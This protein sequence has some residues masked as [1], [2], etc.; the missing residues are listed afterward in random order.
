MPYATQTRYYYKTESTSV[1]YALDLDGVIEIGYQPATGGAAVSIS[2]EPTWYID[3]VPPEGLS[4]V[5]NGIAFD[6]AGE[7]HFTRDG[8]LFRGWNPT[9][10]AATSAG[11][12][13]T[14]GRINFTSVPAG[15]ANAISWRNAAHDARGALDIFGGVYRVA[16]APIKEGNFF[17]QAGALTSSADN[18]GVITGAFTGQVDALR[19]IVAWSVAGLGAGDAEGA[20]VRADEVT[21]S[22]V[23][24]QYVPKDEALLG[25]STTRLPIDGKVPIYRPG[26]HGLVHNTLPTVLPNPLVKGTVYD[27][28]RERI[29]AA[30]VRTPAGVK[31]PGA[32]YQ[33]EFDAGTFVVPV[34]SDLT[35]IDQPLT[36][37]HR[38]EDELE[39]SIADISGKLDFSTNTGL[40]HAYP[41]DTSFVSSKLRKGDLFAR[42]HNFFEQETWTDVWS[43]SLI[44]D[45]P[46]AQ[47]NHVDYPPV[48]TNRG[49][50]KERWALIRTGATTVNVIGEHVG[51]L[52]T[53]A[54]TTAA[55]EPMNPN[56]G[57]PYWSIN[58]LAH[59]EGW[60]VG[61]VLRFNTEAAG[62]PFWEAL[63]ILQGPPT[64]ANDR[65]IV[66]FRSDVDNPA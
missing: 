21:Y 18:A 3:T 26:G 29:A 36:V 30:D 11:S 66:A 5:T 58:P 61:E 56:Q 9:T 17:Q 7:R 38:I 54:S 1:D 59:G 40:T 63:A 6:W 48:V 16:S 35:G 52:L 24:Q 53:N 62:S 57:V 44:G 13:S 2:V 34:E 64:V 27:L 10:G 50:I 8:A 46:T 60:G 43:D 25:I 19:G 51:Q 32:L 47:F 31:V 37:F 14:D 45:A 33:V 42:A 49:S 55:I 28:G 4:L 39:I 12:A 65:A 15:G 22:A 41:A 20:P 23:F